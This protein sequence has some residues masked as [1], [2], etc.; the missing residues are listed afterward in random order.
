MALARLP[1][2]SYENNYGYAT[3]REQKSKR[4]AIDKVAVAIAHED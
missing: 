2:A 1:L 3:L 4:I